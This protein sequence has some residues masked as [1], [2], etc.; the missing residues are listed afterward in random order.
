MLQ[1]I[2]ISNGMKQGLTLIEL[3]I[4][5]AVV[6]TVLVLASGFAW[7]I[8]QG[9]IKTASYREIQQNGRLAIEKITRAIR[10]GQNPTTVFSVSDGVLYQDGIAVTTDQ[11]RVTGL[12]FTSINNTY[13]ITIAIEYNNLSGR[14]EYDASLNLVSTASARPRI[15]E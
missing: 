6:A 10:A 2:G 13:R 15:E 14:N 1:K 3:I 4:Y 8:I 12:Q 11:A 9:S 5:I 7:N